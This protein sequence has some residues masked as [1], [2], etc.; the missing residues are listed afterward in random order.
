M[1]YFYWIWWEKRKKFRCHIVTFVSQHLSHVLANQTGAPEIR[2]CLLNSGHKH[3]SAS[4]PKI[5]ICYMMHESTF[6]S[7]TTSRD[8]WPHLHRRN[9]TP[10]P[11][12][13]LACG[14]D[15]MNFYY[16]ACV[17]H[18]V[19]LFLLIFFTISETWKCIS[20]CQRAP[21]FLLHV[22]EFGFPKSEQ[23]CIANL[24]ILRVFIYLF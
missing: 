13:I 19:C 3:H 5:F 11:P 10:L 20:R 4:T 21:I 22:F 2:P 16:A 14:G 15:S 18:S 9:M 1:R 8:P 17:C 23:V 12:S 24:H 7:H 6:S